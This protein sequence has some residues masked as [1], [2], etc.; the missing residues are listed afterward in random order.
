MLSGYQICV[1]PMNPATADKT[2]I[3]SWIILFQTL[4]FNATTYQR[5]KVDFRP[6]HQSKRKRTSG[7]R[8]LNLPGVQAHFER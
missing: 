1:P 3:A 5:I 4:V 8:K 7:V 2:V 6:L